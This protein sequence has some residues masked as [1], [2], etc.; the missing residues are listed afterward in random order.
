MV[1]DPDFLRRSSDNPLRFM[2]CGPT[3]GY[4]GDAQNGRN[5]LAWVLRGIAQK[6]HDRFGRWE[7]R[8]KSKEAYVCH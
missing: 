5:E 4:A 1:R 6:S 8:V 3:G 2:R 7:F